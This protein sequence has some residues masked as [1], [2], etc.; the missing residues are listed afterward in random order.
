M[1]KKNYLLSKSGKDSVCVCVYVCVC[2]CVCVFE[3]ERKTTLNSILIQ[4]SFAKH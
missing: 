4:N 1:K 3:K 2:V